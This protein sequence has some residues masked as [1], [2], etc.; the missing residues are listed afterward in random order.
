MK[1]DFRFLR[2]SWSLRAIIALIMGLAFGY[3]VMGQAHAQPAEKFSVAGGGGLKNGS[4]YSAMLGDLASVCSTDALAIEET[5]TS[6]GVENLELLKTNKVKSAVVPTDLLMNARRENPASV[7]S[8]K[9]LFAMHPEE[10]HFIARDGVKTEGGVSF[11]GMNVG[12]S[13]VSYNNVED[14]K[15][16]PVGAVGGSVVTAQVVS[17]FLKL[18]LQVTPFADNTKLIAALTKG[19]IDAAVVVAGAPSGAVKALPAGGFKLMPILMNAELAAVYTPTKLQYANLSNNKVVDTIS[20]QAL[21]VTRTFRS[22]EMMANLGALRSCFY[23][24]LPKIQDKDGTH[25]KWQVVD[26]NDRGKWEWY[27]LPV[28]KA[29]AVAAAEPAVPAK[30][31]KK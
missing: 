2:T 12:G 10:V 1:F 22:A 24:S 8:I 6:G 14:L 16:R 21:F 11:A 25:A 4:T 20:T 17:F 28:V 23:A 7:A 9:T 3:F 5:N 27:D 15:G 30:T 13:K 18:G 26:G 29:P 31:K 19:E